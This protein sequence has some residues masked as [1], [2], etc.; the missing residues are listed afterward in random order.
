MKIDMPKYQMYFATL[1]GEVRHVVEIDEPETLDQ[2]VGEI[3]FDLKQRGDVLKGEGEPQVFA[4][5]EF[6]D[7]SL[8]LPRQDVKPNDVLRVSLMPVNG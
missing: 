5:G 1:R 6:L 8:P 3:L 4:N 7:L 2:V